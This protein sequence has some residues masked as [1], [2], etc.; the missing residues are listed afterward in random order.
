V[1]NNYYDARAS[2]HSLSDAFPGIPVNQ[3][4]GD[5]DL[6]RAM[7]TVWK[8]NQVQRAPC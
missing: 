2:V 1:Y 6:G 4:D 5:V 8:D 3:S 7:W